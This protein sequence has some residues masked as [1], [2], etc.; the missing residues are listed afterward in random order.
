MRVYLGIAAKRAGAPLPP[1]GLAAALAA[2]G[3]AFPVP[4]ETVTAEEW[5]SGAGDVA[6]LAWSNEP[7]DGVLPLLVRGDGV[8][9]DRRV[10]GVTGH[11]ADPA[12]AA[13]LLAAA[14]LGETACRTGGCFSVFRAGEGELT[15]ATGMT[16]ACPVFHAETPD[17]H[18]VGNR[19]LLVHLVARA[20][21]TG[22]ARPAVAWNLP[23]LQSMVRMG[24]FL[25]DETP[26]D[27]VRALPPTTEIGIVRGLAATGETPPPEAR[28]RPGSA[29]GMRA[30]ADELAA[31]LL[32]SVRPLAAVTEPVRLSLTGGRDSRL[33]AAL[34]HHAGIPFTT[35]TSGREGT[36]DVVLARRVA[37]ALGVEHRAVE[38]KRSADAAHLVVAHPRVRA[39]NV[40]RVCEGMLSAYENVPE[41]AGFDP[42][43]RMSGHGGEVLRAGF[44]HNQEDLGVA[45]MRRRI[46]GLFTRNADLLSREAADHAR[47]LAEPWRRRGQDDPAGTLDRLYLTYRVGRWHAASRAAL[48][49]GGTPV[50]PFL[51]NLVVRTAL[52]I[53]P[54]WRRSE[55]VVH[56]CIVAFAP[57]L[58][59]VP[60]EGRPWRFAAE[61]AGRTLLDRVRRHLRDVPSSIAGG[62]GP[63]A[64]N[65]RVDVPQALAAELRA[66]VLAWDGTAVTDELARVVDEA[67]VAG[68]F[69]NLPATPEGRPKARRPHVA[70][71]LYTVAAMLA[72]G[73]S[74]SAPPADAPLR[75][76]D[77][78]DDRED[79]AGARAPSGTRA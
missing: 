18:V 74:G 34:L 31:A 51:D 37:A 14:R 53:D 12:D 60:I 35:A 24:Y 59:D 54:M 30:Q 56:R 48:L 58:R 41:A 45:A 13:R 75:I 46:E 55:E 16:G 61:P 29:R 28:P 32:A 64:W 68:L 76:A 63:K 1:V 44:L 65:W 22:T 47:E 19:A 11:L 49:R 73:F 77:P 70:W 23:A 39:H 42:R 71:H 43:P 67:A 25:S 33:L 27:G 78:V 69:A 10:A 15:A 72:D 21:M 7:E 3:R 2:I 6:L 26:F 8:R 40:V 20:V 36:A 79:Q 50:P 66:G 38:P 5:R 62:G 52:S 17:V 9:G 57:G 4:A